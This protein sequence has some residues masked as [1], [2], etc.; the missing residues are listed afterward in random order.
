MYTA[1]QLIEILKKFDQNSY[2]AI[3]HEFSNGLVKS[4]TALKVNQ[5]ERYCSDLK[6]KKKWRGN[7]PVIFLSMCDTGVTEKDGQLYG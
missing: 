2:V 1:A 3:Q 5:D 4:V 6:I 7:F